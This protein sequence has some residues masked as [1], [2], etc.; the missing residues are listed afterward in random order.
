MNVRG[1]M[2]LG[3]SMTAALAGTASAQQLVYTPIN[4]SFGGNPLNSTQLFAEANAQNKYAN[5]NSSS[6]TQ[7]QAQLFAQ[8]LQSEILSD[9]ADQVT[10]SIFGP[11]AQNSGT[12]SFGGETVS[13]TRS[14]GEVT[15]NITAG[16][17]TTTIQ[18]PTSTNTSSG[19]SVQ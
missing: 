7:T 18:V 14:L 1:L 4:P 13:F 15:V 5:Q 2:L 3:C 9:L 16:G 19:V 8:Q 12:F 17:T 6:S 10:S 11:N